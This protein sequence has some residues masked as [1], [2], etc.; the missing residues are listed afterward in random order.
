MKK[1]NKKKLPKYWLGTMKP[2]NKGYQ[3]AQ[4]VE[5]AGFSNENPG[6]DLTP[7]AN[8]TRRNILPNALSKASQIGINLNNILRDTVKQTTP[9][10]L[11]TASNAAINAAAAGGVGSRLLSS[12]AG[13]DYMGSMFTSSGTNLLG[14]KAAET[15]GK[16]VA[17]QAG[18]TAIGSAGKAL[19]AIGGIYS[20]GSMINDISTLDDII[21]PGDMRNTAST[22]YYTTPEG[23]RYIQHG[24]IDT[25]A[26]N[27]LENARKI[28]KRVNLAAD[29]AGLATGVL[30]AATTINPMLGFVA[31]P[32]AYGLSSIFGWGDNSDEIKQQEI[33]TS[34]TL[35]M[36]NRQN[37]SVAEDEDVK[38]AFYVRAA[39]G[40]QPVYSAYGPTNEKENALLSPGEL[41]YETE[42]GHPDKIKS[43]YVIPGKRTNK[44][45]YADNIKAVVKPETGILSNQP[46]PETGIPFSDE[47]IITGDI[48]GVQNRQNIANAMKKKGNFK[49]GKKPGYWSGKIGEYAL[50]TIPGIN[51]YLTNLQ[52][53]NKDKYASVPE[54]N[55]EVTTPGA[56]AAINQMASDMIDPREYLNQSNKTYRQALWNTQR[57]PGMGLGGRAIMAD[58]LTRAKL[59]QDAETRMKIDEANREQRN[60]SE[61]YRIDNDHFIT[62]LTDSNF[63][64]SKAM[65]QQGLGAKY[66]N[67]KSDA[68]NKSMGVT[69]ALSNALA[70]KQYN[71]ALDAQAQTRNLYQQQI[72]LDKLKV[73]SDISRF[74][75]PTGQFN[76]LAYLKY[77]APYGVMGLSNLSKTIS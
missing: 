5:D 27:K 48:L 76:P 44:T 9:S 15:A 34:N 45:K 62:Q 52:W 16:E 67:M 23:N 40:K 39:K 38:R 69:N 55:Y 8:A 75:N 30:A 36:E 49:C 28:T 19:G 21:S 65:L 3:K 41:A 68:K 47:A 2:I 31:A 1:K 29:A 66:T 71:Q 54:Y 63:W 53:Y 25:G 22:N 59:A 35:A 18:K 74:G 77:V 70:V 73:L 6:E 43:I 57:T 61:K 12:G 20:L 50:A 10:I 17:K 37:K 7:E 56:N 14:Q 33:D 11:G 32:V 26:I 13:A 24:G 4:T 64:R 72:N 60:L 58:S 51:E 42:P 46:D